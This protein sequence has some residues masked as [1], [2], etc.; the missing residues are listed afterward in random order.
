MHSTSLKTLL[1]RPSIIGKAAKEHLRP[2]F[3]AKVHTATA[4]IYVL[5]KENFSPKCSE[6]NVY[7]KYSHCK[8]NKPMFDKA[9]KTD[10]KRKQTSTRFP[11]LTTNSFYGVCA[12]LS[13]ISTWYTAVSHEAVVTYKYISARTFQKEHKPVGEQILL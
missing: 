3:L 6:T 10:I 4:L 2:H 9:H 8:K 5:T 12:C 13:F 1:E 7:K 11:K